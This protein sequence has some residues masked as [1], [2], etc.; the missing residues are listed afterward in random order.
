MHMY[1]YIYVNGLCPIPLRVVGLYCDLMVVLVLRTS[2][3]SGHFSLCWQ[4]AVLSQ[5][6]GIA[7]HLKVDLKVCYRAHSNHNIHTHYRILMHIGLNWP[8][9]ILF[10]HM[11]F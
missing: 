9:G 7:E 10:G 4:A 5:V 6:S 8:Y 3:A 11:S 2:G 1:I